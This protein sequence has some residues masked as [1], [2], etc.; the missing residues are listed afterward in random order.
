[1]LLLSAGCAIAALVAIP[2]FALVRKAR[3]A[4]L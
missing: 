1:M 4:R 2:L 3:N